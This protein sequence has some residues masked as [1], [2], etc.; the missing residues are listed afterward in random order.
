MEKRSKNLLGNNF[1]KK[2]KK[3]L[4]GKDFHTIRIKSWEYYEQIPLFQLQSSNPEYVGVCIQVI[5]QVTQCSIGFRF[6]ELE[7]ELNVYMD[8]I[9]TPESNPDRSLIYVLTN[10]RFCVMESFLKAVR[11]R[12]TNHVATT[13]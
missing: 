13:S 9:G 11:F 5:G 2:C 8:S 7:K 6:K 1:W 12:L 4:C 3:Y 10:N